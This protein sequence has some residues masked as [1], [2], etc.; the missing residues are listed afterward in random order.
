MFVGLATIVVMVRGDGLLLR[1][2]MTCLPSVRWVGRVAVGTCIPA[3][4]PADS[5]LSG[6]QNVAHFVEPRGVGRLFA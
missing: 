1:Q 2:S 3:G 4:R 5:E 6:V